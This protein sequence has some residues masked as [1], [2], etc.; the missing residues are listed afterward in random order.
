[1]ELGTV[2][3]KR[4][5]D[6]NCFPTLIKSEKLRPELSRKLFQWMMELWK[7]F[8]ESSFEG[9]LNAEPILPSLI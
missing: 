6:L 3:F 9:I 8:I 5:P 1:M 7:G 2:T 4:F